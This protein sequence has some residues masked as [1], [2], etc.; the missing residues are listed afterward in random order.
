MSTIPT[1]A[2]RCV[3]RD[4]VGGQPLA[5]ATITARLSS[6]EIYEGFVV[7]RDVFAKTDANGEATINLFPN[8]LGAA[9]SFYDIK[10]LS[11]TGKS[12][13]TVAVVPSAPSAELSDISDVPPYE[14]KLNVSLSEINAVRSDVLVAK[15]AAEVAASVAVPAAAVAADKAAEAGAARSAA[16]AAKIGSEAAKAGAEVAQQGALTASG[17]FVDLPAFDAAAANGKMGGIRSSNPNRAYDIAQKVGGVVS[18]TGAAAASE[19]YVRATDRRTVETR[20]YFASGGSMRYKGAGTK[21]PVVTDVNNRALL[22]YDA[23]A[24]SFFGQGLVVSSTLPTSVRTV[25]GSLSQ[26]NYKGAGTLIIPFVSDALNRALLWWDVA[27]RKWK[28]PGLSD[29]GGVAATPLTYATLSDLTQK[30]V[31]KAINHLLFYGQSLSIGATATTILSTTQPYQNKTFASGPRAAGNDYSAMKPLVEDALP[32]PDGASNRGET[33]CSGAAN[34]AT[35][36]AALAGRDPASHVIFASTAG[37]GGYRIDQLNKGTAWYPQ[38]VAHA[39]GAHALNADHAVHAIGWIQGENDAV[40][41]TRTP[42]ATYRAALEQLQVDMD[43]D[44]RAITGQAVPIYVL[45]YQLSY[46]ARAWPAQAKAQLDLAQKNDKFVLVTPI[47]HLPYAADNVHLTSVGYKRLGAYFGKFYK[48]LVLDGKRP[49]WLNP[50][51]ATRRGTVIRVRFDV[52]VAPLVLDVTT[53]ALTTDYGFR[54]LDGVSTAAI[55]SI[56]VDGS[57]LVVTLAALPA[58]AVTFRAGLDYI[59]A[60]LTFTEGAST[61]LRDSDPS[62]ISIS[63]TAYPLYNVCPHFDM[64]VVTLGE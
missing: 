50:I 26:A 46:A 54:V 55:S 62:V 48:T 44:I 29:G 5:G 3:V 36:L 14:G 59:G 33:V 27:A 51:S 30:P 25:I 37:H 9:A 20:G 40:S 47:Y 41:G 63:G 32:A 24:K 58:G 23:T 13:R 31:A 43:T 49:K 19:S 2:V 56:A 45:T 61:N 17:L 39:A 18:L 11:P 57:D 21:H 16:E 64:S 53:M 60:G 12:L 7:P 28:G 4:S 1:C 8:Q 38:L 52:P 10:I 6:Y 15:D 42:Y 22:W 34:Y 35:S